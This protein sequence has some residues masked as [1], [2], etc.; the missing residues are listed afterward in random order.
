MAK[1]NAGGKPKK[2][3]KS[4]TQGK[5]PSGPIAGKYRIDT[6]ECELMEDRFNS[7]GWVLMINGV[8]SSH[9]DLDNPQQLDFEYM[10]W[11]SGLIESHFDPEDGIRALHLGGGACTLA[12]YV[13]S[14]FP[15]SRQV[16]VEIDGKLASLVREW[17]DLPRA[18]L[19]RIRVGEAREVTTSLTETSRDLIIRDVFSG[20]RTPAPLTTVEFTQ[21]VRR[22][23]SPG[24]LY[25]ANCGDTPDRELL[26]T[27]AATIAS[28]FTYV[29]F[30][31]DA[32][33]LKGRR[34]GNVIIA[35]SDKPL[36]SHQ[37]TRKLRTI[38]LPAQFWDDA[39]V[40]T[41]AASAQPN[42]D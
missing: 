34:Y 9:I 42:V 19:L 20:S 8:P 11:I 24:G 40:R 14:A 39:R 30:V 4:R 23:L 29:A 15:K 31:A 26:K 22:V 16:V 2:G 41:F 18:P 21:Q 1:G 38:G 27:E 10:H 37:L 25:L 7:N 28:L 3:D 33:M 13:A 12:R 6:G 5:A 17:F 32:T 36:G 35:G